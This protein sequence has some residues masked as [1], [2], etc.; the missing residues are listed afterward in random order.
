VQILVAD[1]HPLFREVLRD[2]VAEA[3]PSPI[4][5]EAQNFAE[6]E[7]AVS[8][9][10]SLG[11]ALVDLAL[12]GIEGLAG[13]LRLSVLRPS[14]PIVVV[15]AVEGADLARRS[16]VCGAVGFLPKSLA[17]ERMWTEIRA[18]VGI[19]C[20]RPAAR[21]SADSERLDV[22][23][24]RERMVLESMVRGRSN[25]QTAYELQITY[26]TVK[27]HVSSILRKLQ[28]RSRIQ[29]IIATRDCHSA[30]G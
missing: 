26:T 18:G 30:D 16:L 5:V 23:T 1:R 9:G 3:L 17:R 4:F 20:R 7:E 10:E 15:S 19:D 22:L 6:A 2:V 25:K 8:R 27:V 28:V 14:M 29:A 11:L 13:V 21:H 12:G 24:L